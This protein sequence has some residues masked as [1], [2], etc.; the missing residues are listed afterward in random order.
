MA[1]YQVIVS[2]ISS[3]LVPV[4]VEADTEE[5]AAEMVMQLINNGEEIVDRATLAE[6]FDQQIAK[7][8]D[9]ECD[10]IDTNLL[11]G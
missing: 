9:Y 6:A 7:G 11:E 2:C 5:D 3:V 10:I 8:G 4:S 1:K